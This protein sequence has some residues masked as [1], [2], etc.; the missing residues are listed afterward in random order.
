MPGFKQTEIGVIPTEWEIKTCGELADR[1]MVGVV[2]RPTQYYVASGVPALRSANVRERGIDETDLVFFSNS[3]NEL[4]SK[5]QVR[6]GDVLT[7]RTGYPGTSAVATHH[8]SGWNCI[9][10]LITRPRKALNSEF[11]ARWINSSFGKEQ[12]LRKQGGLAQKHFNVADMKELLIA[13]PDIAEQQ[14]IAQVLSDADALIE[15]LEQLLAKKRKM[16]QGAMQELLKGKIRLSGFRDEWKTKSLDEL[17]SFSGGFAASRD[18]L[19][20]VG[21]C[22]LH[23]GDIHTSDKT[24]VDVRAE[25][26]HIPKLDIPLKMIAQSALLD[27]GDVVFV[28]ASEDDEGTSR[29]LVIAN[30]DREPFISG[31]HTIVAK[32]KSAEIN[33]L[34]RR[35]CFQTF[36][37]KS[38]FRFLAVGTKVSGVSKTNI[39]RIQI[40]VPM[41]EE[42]ATIA[43]ILSDMD[44]E[45]TILDAKLTKAHQLK[46]GMMQALLTGQIRLPLDAA[47]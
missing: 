32:A 35:F 34:Y 38:Q 6:V 16:K 45:L 43:A 41:L 8:H 7:V 11:L 2:I 39:V 15:S 30:P 4:L 3:S 25:F 26:Q 22:Y 29:H 28:D 31:L 36:A 27:D 13:V 17:F 9:D 24:F 37:V 1:V 46:L 47:Q 19:S 40:P 5:S 33:H 44:T 10:I 12:V 14:A 42:Q 23:Y 18:Q 20:S 21:H